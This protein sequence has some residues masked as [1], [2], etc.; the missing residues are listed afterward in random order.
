MTNQIDFVCIRP[1][2]QALALGDALTVH[3]ETWGY[4]PSGRTDGHEWRSC[5]DTGLQA[6]VILMHREEPEW[7]LAQSVRLL[8]VEHAIA[9]ASGASHAAR[10]RASARAAKRR[11]QIASAA[12][13]D[14]H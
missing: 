11:R 13:G 14:S 3:D 4:C 6:H 8:A 10:T 7:T 1:D 9:H 12:G 2:H 5:R